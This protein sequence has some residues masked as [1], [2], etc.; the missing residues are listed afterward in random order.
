MNKKNLP[1]EVYEF[2]RGIG[3][4]SGKKILKERGPEYFSKISKMRK[5]HGRQKTEETPSKP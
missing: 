1:P 3:E 5:V 4:K 2:F